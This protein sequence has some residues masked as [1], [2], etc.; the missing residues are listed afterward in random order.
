MSEPTERTV[1]VRVKAPSHDLLVPHREQPQRAVPWCEEHNC[2]VNPQPVIGDRMVPDDHPD[3]QL[4]CWY[5]WF[6]AIPVSDC[7]LEDAPKH[8]EDV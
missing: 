6:M 1:L 2:S 8:W 3:G 7:R 4:E 5:R